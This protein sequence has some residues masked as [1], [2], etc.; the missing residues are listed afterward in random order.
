M[1]E[2]PTWPIRSL[3]EREYTQQGCRHQ[4]SVTSDDGIWNPA[5]KKMS[6]A[7]LH[8]ADMSWPYWPA[9]IDKGYARV[10]LDLMVKGW[11]KLV[12]HAGAACWHDALAQ[13]ADN[14]ATCSL[15]KSLALCDK[16]SCTNNPVQTQ[17]V[18]ALDS[19][20]LTHLTQRT[21]F[22]ENRWTESRI[23]AWPNWIG[24]PSRDSSTWQPKKRNGK[25]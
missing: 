3:H 14:L 19:D 16:T 24:I 1:L 23:P 13:Y 5:S 10:V 8:W 11:R 18:V 6:K 15:V 9:C 25:T 12:R 17:L 4:E 7:L 2:R 20:F 21:S 22:I